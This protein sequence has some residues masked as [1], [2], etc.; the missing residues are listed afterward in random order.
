MSKH[1]IVCLIPSRLL[2]Q[3][4]ADNNSSWF[5]LVTYSWQTLLRPHRWLPHQASLSLGFSRQE[6]WSCLPLPPPGDLPNPGIEPVSPALAGGCFTTEPPGKP[7][8]SQQ[9]TEMAPHSSGFWKP[10][11]KASRSWLSPQVLWRRPLLVCA[12]CLLLCPPLGWGQGSL[13]SL[14]YEQLIL[15]KKPWLSWLQ[16]LLLA[17]TRWSLGFQNVT[18][19]CGTNTQTTMHD[20]LVFNVT[21]SGEGNGSALQYSCLENLMNRGA[22]W[23]IVHGVTRVK[24]NL[25]TKPPLVQLINF[26]SFRKF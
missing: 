3:K 1:Y 7:Q 15:C 19:R 9:T 12:C 4:M 11:L 6:Y 13:W 18:R 21:Y 17:P 10:S 26:I 25:V 2:W 23:A 5:T 8:Y 24:H 14:F 22:W 20:L 16:H